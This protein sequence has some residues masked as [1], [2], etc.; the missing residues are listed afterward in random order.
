MAKVR[1]AASEKPSPPTK[2]MTEEVGHSDN[3]HLPPE[4]FQSCG[5]LWTRGGGA[6]E[7]AERQFRG[8][9]RSYTVKLKLKLK[10]VLFVCLF[11]FVIVL[12][13]HSKWE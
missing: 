5:P 11:I 13:L 12:D 4:R 7:G 8:K 9:S 6:E 1:K 2:V 3:H 10:L